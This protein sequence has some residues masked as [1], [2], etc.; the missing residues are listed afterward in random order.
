[1]FK[2]IIMGLV[3][4]MVIINNNIKIENRRGTSNLSNQI[5][6]LILTSKIKFLFKKTSK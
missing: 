6:K 3:I 2:E 1:M 4:V 5:I